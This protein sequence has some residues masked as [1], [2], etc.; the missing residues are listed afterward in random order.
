MIS[1]FSFAKDIR[2]RDLITLI[3]L[4]AVLYNISA[5]GGPFYAPRDVRRAAAETMQVLFPVSDEIER[6]KK[7][8]EGKRSRSEEKGKGR[9][10]KEKRRKKEERGEEE[11]EGRKGKEKRAYILW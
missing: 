10:E 2:F 5:P 3:K 7:G 8:R 11:K 1:F 4:Q 9:R 6:E